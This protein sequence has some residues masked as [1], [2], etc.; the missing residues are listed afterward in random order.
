MMAGMNFLFLGN[1]LAL[2]FVNTYPLIGEE[3]VELL[4]DFATLLEWFKA[5]GLMDSKSVGGML[6]KW[7][8]TAKARRTVEDLRTL[9]ET[10]RAELLRW[11]SGHRVSSAMCAELN[12]LL[13]RYPMRARLRPQASGVRIESWFETAE[14][15]QLLAPVVDAI[16]DLF[17]NADRTRVRKCD[18]CV[19]HFLDT[20]KKG[21]RRWCSMQLCGNRSKVAAYAARQAPSR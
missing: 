2:D 12:E 13:A 14:P 5:A 21:T 9:R 11:E 10:L 15:A 7:D 1:H 18:S 17:A 3:R 8:G 20:S 19:G 16:A 4:P 6:R